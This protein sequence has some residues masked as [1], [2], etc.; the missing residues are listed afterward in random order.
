MGGL[1]FSPQLVC[2][3]TKI[4]G[5]T[6]GS[7]FF[8]PIGLQP[9]QNFGTYR[10]V[11][12]F[13]PNWSATVPKF[14][15]VEE[16]LSFS[17]Q[18][19]CDRT[20][21]LGHTGGSFFFT[22]IGLRLYQNFGTYRRVFLFHPNLGEDLTKTAQPR[23][24]VTTEGVLFFITPIGSRPYQNFGNFRKKNFEKEIKFFFFFFFLKSFFHTRRVFLF[25]P[26][27]PPKKKKN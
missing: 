24:T 3:L 4:L 5:H 25:P 7:F 19:V 10:R 23:P 6:G 8:T 16:G 13:H 26:P 17:P 11:F 1:S 9:Y 21:I 27:P 2:N 22:P 14:W 12:L 20:K 15:D 18:L